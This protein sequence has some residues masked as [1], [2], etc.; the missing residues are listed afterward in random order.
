MNTVTIATKLAAAID[1]TIAVTEHAVRSAKSEGTTFL[2]VFKA[3]LAA[4]RA[5]R[6]GPA[7]QIDAKPF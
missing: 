6:T 2:S 4:R 1:S 3:E 5:A 7:P